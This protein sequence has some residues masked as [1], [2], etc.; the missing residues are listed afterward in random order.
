MRLEDVVLKA[1]RKDREGRFQNATEF[2]EELDAVARGCGAPDGSALPTVPMAVP[3]A[4][5]S[6]SPP[7]APNAIATLLKRP[8]GRA[9][10]PGSGAGGSASVPAGP[11]PVERPV[12]SARAAALVGGAV[13]IAVAALA[14]GTLRSGGRPCDLAHKKEPVDL[15]LLDTNARGYKRFRHS[16]DGA[17]MVLIPAGTFLMGSEAAADEGPSRDTCLP[18]FYIDEREVTRAQFRAFL[19]HTGRPPAGRFPI[20]SGAS[21]SSEEGMLPATGVTWHDAQAYAE[22]A[23]RRLPSEAEW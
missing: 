4:V 6:A 11:G 14:W 20:A 5:G 21:R 18:E 22:W 9:T 16:R 10:D 3:R 15:S 12:R 2:K 17:I 1:L 13:L 7:P 19:A 23:G 8:E